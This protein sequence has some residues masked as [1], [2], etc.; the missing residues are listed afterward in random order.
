MPIAGDAPEK[1]AAYP[2]V[3]MGHV[4]PDVGDA[5]GEEQRA[6]LERSFG[7][8]NTEGG[9]G[10]AGIGDRG[11]RLI[12]ALDALDPALLELDPETLGLLPAQL[13]QLS[14]GDTFGKTQIVLVDLGKRGAAFSGV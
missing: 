2:L 9:L 11:S 5:G 10:G 3:D 12:A 6:S 8:V 1:L 14:G 7:G 13:P 4:R